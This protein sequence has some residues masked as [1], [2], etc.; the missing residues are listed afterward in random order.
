MTELR[1]SHNQLGGIPPDLFQQ[2]GICESLHTI[3]LDDNK[4]DTAALTIPLRSLLQLKK[5]QA[6]TNAVRGPFV[7]GNELPNELLQ[8]RRAT[9]SPLVAYQ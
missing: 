6:S 4:L 9:C 7:D 8:V 3:F 5:L 1:A 2:H